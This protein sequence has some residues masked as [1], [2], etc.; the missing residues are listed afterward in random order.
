MKVYRA[1]NKTTGEYLK[2]SKGRTIWLQKNHLEI[3][4]EYT[5]HKDLYN[6]LEYILVPIDDY[7]RLMKVVDMTRQLKDFDPRNTM[8]WFT[9]YDKDM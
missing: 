4:R 5:Q 8:N 9:P 2:S 6:I 3:T 1:I 7:N